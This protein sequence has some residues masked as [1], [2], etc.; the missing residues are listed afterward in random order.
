MLDMISIKGLE[1]FAYH[2]V[3]AEEKRDG[4]HFY[5][6]ITMGADLQKACQS[7]DLTA[8]V[9]YAA[10]RKTV[11]RVFTEKSYDLIARASQVCADAI[12]QEFPLV[13]WVEITL[14]KPEAPM[15]AV[16]DYVAVTIRRERTA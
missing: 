7:D 5:L 9:N 3:N 8:T 1:L 4:Q 6:D 2:G 14:K 11:Q 10:V 16:F 13:Q 15:S 12:L